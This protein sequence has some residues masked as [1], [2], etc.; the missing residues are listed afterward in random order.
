[1][2]INYI[3]GSFHVTESAEI[4]NCP[5]PSQNSMILTPVVGI[6]AVKRHHKLQLNMSI[7]SG[8]MGH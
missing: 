3:S 7:A 4:L 5:P 2:L 8:D 1:M 6:D